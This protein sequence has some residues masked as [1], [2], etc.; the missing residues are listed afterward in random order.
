M[1]NEEA[2]NIL[3][4]A[5]NLVDKVITHLGNNTV[6]G[7]TRDPDELVSNL[8]QVVDDLYRSTKELR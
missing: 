5:S 2:I 8:S 7:Y 6:T 3:N 4:E 1:T